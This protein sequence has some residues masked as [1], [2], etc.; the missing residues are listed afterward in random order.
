MS[1]VNKDIISTYAGDYRCDYLEWENNIDI[2]KLLYYLV[3]FFSKM[4]I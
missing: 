4:K 1:C 3:N 2:D